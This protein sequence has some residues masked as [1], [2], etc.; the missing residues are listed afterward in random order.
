VGIS[1]ALKKFG[2]LRA[3]IN[4]LGVQFTQINTDLD[5]YVY[6]S[7]Q[8]SAI[9]TFQIS[10]TEINTFNWNAVTDCILDYVKYS[11]GYD[12]GMFF[13]GYY[14]DDV[15]GQAINKQID[16]TK[17]PQGCKNCLQGLHNLYAYNLYNKFV[18]IKPFSVAPSDEALKMFD[19]DDVTYYEDSTFGLNLHITVECD[20]TDLLTDNKNRF[21][22]VMRKQMGVDLLKD[23][24]YTTRDNIFEDRLVK[25]ALTE[26]KGFD[27]YSGAEHELRQAYKA[28]DLE[29]TIES[30]CLG[31]K[32][33]GVKS[34]A[35]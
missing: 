35:F 29:M 21:M 12:T 34:G 28:I 1:L 14:E 18:T 16:F 32:K 26:L 33:R 6:H 17:E 11:S 24:A 25:S 19:L 31:K 13:I 7:S 20:I 23:I 10:T 8:N 2:G 15:T 5:I 3:T 27:G 22:D 4:Q 30:P 9:K